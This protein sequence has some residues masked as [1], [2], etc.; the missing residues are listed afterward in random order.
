M[1]KQLNEV[2]EHQVLARNRLVCQ[3]GTKGRKVFLDSLRNDTHDDSISGQTA[4]RE[5]LKQPLGISAEL[6][7]EIGSCKVLAD[8]LVGELKP[9]YIDPRVMKGIASI[10]STS[11]CSLLSPL[12]V[13]TSTRTSSARSRRSSNEIPLLR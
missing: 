1:G 7:G 13:S 12:G 10:C 11:V 2:S 8:N 3:E 9:A 5:P 4:I 6:A